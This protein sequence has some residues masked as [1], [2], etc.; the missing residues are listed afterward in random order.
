MIDHSWFE[1]LKERIDDEGAD[2]SPQQLQT[3]L[4]C[5]ADTVKARLAAGESIEIPGWGRFEA[6]ELEGR[7]GMNPKQSGGRIWIES[8]KVVEFEPAASLRERLPERS[9]STG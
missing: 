3:V 6:R 9:P 7:H 2:L 8:Q 4:E 1:D 5:L